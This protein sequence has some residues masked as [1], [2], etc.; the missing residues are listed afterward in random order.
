MAFY[1]MG[2]I[3]GVVLGPMRPRG[4]GN[5]KRG[6]DQMCDLVERLVEEQFLEP[7]GHLFPFFLGRLG[8]LMCVGVETLMEQTDCEDGF[9]AATGGEFSQLLEEVNVLAFWVEG[10][11]FQEFAQF[12]NHDEEAGSVPC[13][14]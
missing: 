8:K 14:N 4:L 10:R 6:A 11:E 5:I 12:I 2:V 7:S 9:G 1:V 13:G 3:Q